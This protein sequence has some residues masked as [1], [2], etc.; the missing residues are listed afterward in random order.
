MAKSFTFKDMELKF[1]AELGRGQQGTVY[2]VEEPTTNQLYAVKEVRLTFGYGKDKALAEMISSQ[3][4]S[5]DYIVS[6][7]QAKKTQNNVYLLLEYCNGGNIL[8]FLKLNGGQLP[9]R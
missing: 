5:S 3:K 7:T 4:I 1:K 2:L 6:I 8:Q 9:E